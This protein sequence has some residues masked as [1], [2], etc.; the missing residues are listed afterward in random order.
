MNLKKGK[1]FADISGHNGRFLMLY[2]GSIWIDRDLK[3]DANKISF[4]I[5][6]DGIYTTP[7]NINITE[8]KPLIVS[9]SIKLYEPERNRERPFKIVYNSSLGEHA[10]PAR[11]YTN[12]LPA[13]IEIGK[14]FF[15][16]PIQ[17]RMFIL[18]HE[19]GHLYY[20]DEHKCD[21]FALKNFIELGYNIS[22]GFYALSKV[23]HPN[24]TNKQRILKLFK[25]I[26]NNGHIKEQ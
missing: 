8:I 7:N 5:V 20:K 1:Y 16:Y 25:E 14:R 21:L 10:T 11:I 18:L 2:K 3:H 12:M 26:E 13:K 23:L 9:S 17:V 24:E 19:L 22:Q 15:L 4:N 6:R